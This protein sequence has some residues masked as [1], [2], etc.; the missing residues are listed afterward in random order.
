[1]KNIL[2]T[3]ASSGIG[4][5]IAKKLR[6]KYK[7]INLDIQENTLEGIEFYKCDLSNK[8]QLLKTIKK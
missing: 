2:I 5:Q 4:K 7:V 8:Q 1:M 3:G 6:K